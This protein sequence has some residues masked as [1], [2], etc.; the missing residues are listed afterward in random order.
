MAAIVEA[1]SPVSLEL[2]AMPADQYPVGTQVPI[3]VLEGE[4][5]TVI[6]VEVGDNLRTCLLDNGFEVYVS[7]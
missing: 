5:E 4:K 3:T 7:P 1:P 6:Q 2:E